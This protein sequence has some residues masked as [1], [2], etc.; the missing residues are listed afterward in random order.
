[1]IAT[2]CSFAS[3]KRRLSQRFTEFLERARGG[4]K[5]GLENSVYFRV[6]GDRVTRPVTPL[7]EFENAD[8]LKTL[9]FAD[10][11]DNRQMLSTGNLAAPVTLVFPEPWN[12]V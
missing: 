3:T 6:R 2:T 9:A 1:M 10:Y 7:A 12:S 11:G 4:R 8:P 5:N